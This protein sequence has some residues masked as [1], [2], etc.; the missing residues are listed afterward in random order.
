MLYK[1]RLSD[2]QQEPRFHAAL[3]DIMD[4]FDLLASTFKAETLIEFNWPP[5]VPDLINPNV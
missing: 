5:E 3:L 2:S 4:P 1:Q